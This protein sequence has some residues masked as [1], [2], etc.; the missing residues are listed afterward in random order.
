VIIGGVAGSGV[1]VGG[2]STSGAAQHQAGFDQLKEEVQQGTLRRTGEL[3]ELTEKAWHFIPPPKTEAGPGGTPVWLSTPQSTNDLIRSVQASGYPAL[4]LGSA[5]PP[6]SYAGHMLNP[7][8]HVLDP[9]F[10][11]LKVDY[12]A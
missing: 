4:R 9:V 7:F 8:F 11:G 1:P 12:H 5:F 2:I 3:H 10:G 6:N